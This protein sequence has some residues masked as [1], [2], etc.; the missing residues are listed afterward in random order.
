M[1]L[2]DRLLQELYGPSLARK[3]F[4]CCSDLHV[5]QITRQLEISPKWLPSDWFVT[6]RLYTTIDEMWHHFEADGHLYMYMPSYL[7]LTQ[8][9]GV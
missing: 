5:H 7:C 4:G 3:M 6:T 9:S 1:I 8:F 2:H